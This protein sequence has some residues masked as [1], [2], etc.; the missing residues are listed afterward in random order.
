MDKNFLHDGL[1]DYSHIL[2]LNAYWRP[3]NPPEI[4]GAKLPMELGIGYGFSYTWY[5]DTY[6]TPKNAATWQKP[7]AA[8]KN[9]LELDVKL[10]L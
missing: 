8:L 9:I 3:A 10:F 1:Y 6:Y 5:D 4:F 2:K 7:A